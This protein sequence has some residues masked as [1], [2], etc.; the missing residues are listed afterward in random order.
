LKQIILK[1]CERIHDYVNELI[2]PGALLNIKDN[3]DEIVLDFD[4]KEYFFDLTL[5]KS[6]RKWF[7]RL[8]NPFQKS[9][10]AKTTSSSFR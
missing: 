8:F 10:D 1:A 5:F 2:D 9:N 6:K 4:K 3:N 7:Y